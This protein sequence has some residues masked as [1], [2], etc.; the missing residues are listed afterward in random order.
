M[1]IPSN[2]LTINSAISQELNNIT[3]TIVPTQLTG[4]PS[5]LIPANI[6]QINPSAQSLLG[7]ISTTD[8]V[9][10]I[11][12]Y[13]VLNTAIPDN[14]FTT[15]SIDQ[16]KQRT[17]QAAKLFVGT[18]PIPRIIPQIPILSIAFP[19]RRPSYGNI[20]NFIKTKIDR[21]KRQKQ[22]A[23]TKALQEELKKQENPFEYRN[24]LTT[25]TQQNRANVVLG[26][27]SNQ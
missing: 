9:Q 18:L 13:S 17:L 26:R 27:F 24:R 16:I 23:S 11:P 20:K 15:G 2:L 10:Q 22:I 21:I 14:L 8:A 25:L 3:P 19:P 12:Y 1:P 7:T 4:L 6:N 5:N